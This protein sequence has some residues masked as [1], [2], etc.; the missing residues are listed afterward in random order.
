MSPLKV[1]RY[2]NGT[3]LESRRKERDGEMEGENSGVSDRPNLAT[4]QVSPSP[5]KGVIYG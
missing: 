1:A 4:L 5:F 3:G 2:F